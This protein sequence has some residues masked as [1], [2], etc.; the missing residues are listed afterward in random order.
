M[1]PDRLGPAGPTS[2]FRTHLTIQRRRFPLPEPRLMGVVNAN[3]DSFS[4][5]AT[6]AGPDTGPDLDRLLARA[7]ELVDQGATVL[8]VGGQSGI[9]GVPEVEPEV[10]AQRVVPL[11]AALAREHPGVA[12][13]VDTYKPAVVQAAL[14]A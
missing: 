13:S 9:T 4:D 8:D 6:A 12:I 11:V 7:G 1:P 2:G 14:E 3:P 10:E 5:P